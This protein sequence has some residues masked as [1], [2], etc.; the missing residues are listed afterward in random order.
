MRLITPVLP[1]RYQTA[2]LGLNT[3][4]LRME[5][6]VTLPTR[7]LPSSA[8]CALLDR[9]FPSTNLNT[10]RMLQTLLVKMGAPNRKSSTSGSSPVTRSW[11]ALTTIHI[12]DRRPITPRMTQAMYSLW[13]EYR[14][15]ALLWQ[16]GAIAKD[17]TSRMA[18]KAKKQRLCTS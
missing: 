3:S 9:T 6:P 15:A 13:A 7:E 4:V 11:M 2:V 12:D 17:R 16:H 18:R 14:W 10:A 5:K 8:L 1:S